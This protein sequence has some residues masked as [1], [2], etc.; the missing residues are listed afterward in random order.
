MIIAEVG[1]NHLGRVE[2]AHIYVDK[3]AE[4]DIDGISFQVREKEY[5]LLQQV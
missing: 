3:L 5:Y 1:I 4:T 2:S